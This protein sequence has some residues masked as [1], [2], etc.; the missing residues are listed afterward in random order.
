M[1][2][3]HLNVVHVVGQLATGGAEKLLVEFAKHADRE[4][5]D[6]RFVSLQGRGRVAEEL[7]GSGWPVTAL[8]Q[9]PGLRLGLIFKLARLF[10]LWRADV[11]HTHNAKPLYYGGPAA[12]AAGIKG[13]IHT[14]HGQ[15]FGEGARQRAVFRMLARMADRV[16][17]VSKDSERLSVN[18]GVPR[19]KVCTVLNG[20]DVERFAYRGPAER[21][22][23]V[24]VGRL[25]PEKDPF[26]LVRATAIVKAREP[27]FRLEI[28]GDGECMEELKRLVRELDL[29][30]ETVK[31]LGEVSD[32]PGLLARASVFV[33]P[34]LT[35]GV[36]LTLLEA[37]ARGLPVVATR[38]GGN[39]EVVVEGQT[40]LLVEA[41]DAAGMAEA[42]LRLQQNPQTC[43][44]MG[45]AAC[46]RV[47]GRFDARRMVAEYQDLYLKAMEFETVSSLC[48]STAS[49]AGV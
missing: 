4:R 19:Q 21:G 3:A 12:R 28:A 40:G 27:D 7:E 39:P 13:L 30:E 18:Q 47:K 46:A 15:H 33:L 35:E 26:T 42:L 16:V 8:E 24:M 11:V 14:R 48:P 29:G 2:S 41:G 38:V 20:I 23:V 5:F 25:S 45:T 32:V 17:C 31:L 44:F 6:L 9:R 1:R 37:M 43:R 10:R 49:A 36:S 22:P 34:S